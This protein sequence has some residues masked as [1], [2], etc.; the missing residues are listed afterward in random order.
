MSED[1]FYDEKEENGSNGLILFDDWPRLANGYFTVWRIYGD[2][3]RARHVGL[4]SA[5]L[6]HLRPLDLG[7]VVFALSRCVLHHPIVQL[8]FREDHETHLRKRH[9]CDVDS[10]L[11]AVFRMVLS[12]A[13]KRR[14]R[15]VASERRCGYSRFHQLRIL[16]LLGEFVWN[17]HW[18]NNVGC[19]RLECAR[20]GSCGDV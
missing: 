10:G 13:T 18:R 12:F 8:R 15:P 11:Y 17:G 5:P 2:R 9:V 1:F 14:Q 6:G 4:G 19:M 3:F 7:A 16:Y 20:R